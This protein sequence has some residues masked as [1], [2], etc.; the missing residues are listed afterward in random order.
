MKRSTVPLKKSKP[1]TSKSTLKKSR[2]KVK[3]PDPKYLQDR[4]QQREEDYKFY[5]RLYKERGPHS[6]VSGTYIGA[7][8]LSVNYHHIIAKAGWPEGRYIDENVII[9]TWEEHANVENSMY[10]YEEVN[11]RRELLKEKYGV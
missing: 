4:Q 9:L 8:V 7:E 11:K 1:L 6:E 5:S 10:I 2:M 3:A